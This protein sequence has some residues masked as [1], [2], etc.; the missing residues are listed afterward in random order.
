MTTI[1]VA[2]F[3]DRDHIVAF[4]QAMALETEKLQL[5]VARLQAGVEAVLADPEHGFYLV[6]E[7]ENDIIACLMITF[8]W[9]DWR[10]AWW[11]WVQSVYVRPDCRGSGV[12]RDLYLHARSLSEGRNVCGFRLYVDH[13]NKAAQSTYSALGM[14]EARYR[15]FEHLN[16]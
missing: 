6:A 12:Y 8:E 5:N 9:S 14:S 11:W 10:N 3:A 1:R 15:M 16:D 4:N 13:D 2:N 7:Q